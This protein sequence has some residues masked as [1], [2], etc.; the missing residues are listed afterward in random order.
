MPT[1]NPNQQTL[2]SQLLIDGG[3]SA[4]QPALQPHFLGST[5]IF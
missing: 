1:R 3:M 2:A 4:I 5:S